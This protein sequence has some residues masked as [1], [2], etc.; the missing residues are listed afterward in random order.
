[1]NRNRKIKNGLKEKGGNVVCYGFGSCS[2]SGLDCHADL[3]LA[4]KG[5]AV[6][7]V[8]NSL[9][10]QLISNQ[11]L[12]MLLHCARLAGECYGQCALVNSP[13]LGQDCYRL[14]DF[15][16]QDLT[17]G[18]VGEAGVFRATF[19]RLMLTKVLSRI[20]EYEG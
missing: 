13:C 8:S 10:G 15:R 3:S 18:R 5:G 6:A 4:A 12:Q 19:D 2:S 11:W 1:M 20:R 16:N 7:S 14:G 17:M 9:D